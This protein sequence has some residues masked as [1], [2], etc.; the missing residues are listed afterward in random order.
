LKAGEDPSRLRTHVMSAVSLCFLTPT[1][2]S[3][4]V[5]LYAYDLR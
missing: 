5:Q 1:I 4:K 2:M 3:S